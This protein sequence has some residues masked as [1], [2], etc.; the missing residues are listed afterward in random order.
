V[1]ARLTLL[2]LVVGG[3]LGAIA[4]SRY[5]VAGVAAAAIAVAACHLGTVAALVYG[6]TARA[7]SGHPLHII[8]AMGFRFL[9][10]MAACVV[11]AANQSWVLQAGFAYWLLAA[12]LVLMTSQVWLDVHGGTG[13][14]PTSVIAPRVGKPPVPPGRS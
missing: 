14:S 9:L 3:L 5:G 2:A 4:Y 6:E 8:A 7:F 11:A 13:G 12:Y 10:P 1:L